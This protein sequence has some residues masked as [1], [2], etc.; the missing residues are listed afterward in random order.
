MKMKKLLSAVISTALVLTTLVMPIT[1]KADT[2]VGEG[3]SIID[4]AQ[5]YEDT[6]LNGTIT[7]ADGVKSIGA[8]AFYACSNITEIIIPDSVTSIDDSAF[9]SCTSLE[10]IIIPDSVTFMGPFIFQNCTGLKSV[11]IGSGVTDLTGT[12]GMCTAL[13][14]V[15]FSGNNLKTLDNTFYKCSS[16][17][18]I[19]IPDSVSSIGNSAFRNCT[20]LKNIE[21]PDSATSIGM[22]TF[23]GCTN[24]ESVTIPD[25][26]TSIGMSAFSGCTSLTSI[27]IP[28]SVTSI[29]KNTFNG[30]TNLES[31]SI[32][33]S[34]E[35][36]ATDA[37]N[38]CTDAVI[39]YSG[40]DNTVQDTLENS[41]A[42]EVVTSS[43]VDNIDSESGSESSGPAV[44]RNE[45]DGGATGFVLNML[46]NKVAGADDA[47][48]KI[49]WTV[50]TSKNEKKTFIKEFT[51]PLSINSA[52]DYLT[53]IISG[54]HDAGASIM[55]RL[56]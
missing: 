16:L 6:T 4:D 15:T 48:N 13:E 37:F 34:V 39:Y 25:S 23:N 29:E 8:Y 21:M 3:A 35:S 26:E 49:T 50:T 12:F 32:P 30:C 14:N 27:E 55:M 53:F 24:L 18:S 11:T 54:L 10:K 44:A 17:E 1:A 7:I 42:K 36:V 45:G 28:D 38:G 52:G 19:K 31:V 41:S 33:A 22:N 40:S 9:D 47:I 5:Y 56:N 2:T 43:V 46:A 51:S 20:S